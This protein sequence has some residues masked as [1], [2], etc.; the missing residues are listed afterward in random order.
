VAP[1]D[2]NAEWWMTSDVATH[3]GVQVATVTNY[4]KR[5]QM[6]APDPSPGPGVLAGVGPFGAVAAAL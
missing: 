4:R 6:L 1:A 2:P 3:L 5:H